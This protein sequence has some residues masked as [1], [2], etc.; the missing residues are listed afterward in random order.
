MRF[1]KQLLASMA[2]L[3]MLLMSG[4]A[5]AQSGS[6]NPVSSSGGSAGSG[7]GGGG[8]SSGGFGSFPRSLT[9]QEGALR[10]YSDLVRGVGEANF[11]N[12]QATKEYELARGA[13]IDNQL[14]VAQYRLER[15][16]EKD[17]EKERLREQ[18]AIRRSMERVAKQ[19]S[20][21]ADWEIKWPEPL[22]KSRYATYR[23]EIEELAIL[24]SKL[25]R[26][27]GVETGLKISIEQLAKKIKEDEVA[28]RLL[29]QDS[30]L[31]RSFVTE[32]YQSNGQSALM[33]KMA[34]MLAE[35]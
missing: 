30:K 2:V 27:T 15:R 5:T 1:T 32:L 4:A 13:Y 25:T 28:K 17:R 26:K 10:G 33:K 18:R 14:R 16:A 21:R 22:L 23:I 29:D 3:G 35:R 7:G 24:Y 11:L 31:V 12:A 8:L 6:R 9:P 20:S 34:R 19:S